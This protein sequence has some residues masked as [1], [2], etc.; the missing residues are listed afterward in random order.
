M[1]WVVESRGMME[2]EETLQV[3]IPSWVVD[4]F[5]PSPR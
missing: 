1:L 4:A 2:K 3:P 5:K